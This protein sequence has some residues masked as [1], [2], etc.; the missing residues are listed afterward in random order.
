LAEC[1]NLGP[2]LFAKWHYARNHV[3]NLG[4]D[5]AI[6]ACVYLLH[7]RNKVLVGPDRFS[8]R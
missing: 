2:E 4:F 6:L 7:S 1:N 5:V 8:Y 3:Q